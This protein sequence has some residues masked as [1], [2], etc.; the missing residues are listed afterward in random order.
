MST[1]TTW[2]HG[3]CV[4]CGKDGEQEPRFLY[5]VCKEHENTPPAS[6]RFVHSDVSKESLATYLRDLAVVKDPDVS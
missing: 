3:L 4:F 2:R 5:F 1:Q 6:M